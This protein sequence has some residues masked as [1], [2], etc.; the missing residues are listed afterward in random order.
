MAIAM[1]GPE[2]A[3][4]IVAVT[5]VTYLF[6][7]AMEGL[8]RS[9]DDAESKLAGFNA[10]LGIAEGKAKAAASAI[11]LL[12][13]AARAL[14]TMRPGDRGKLLSTLGDLEGE[15]GQ[16]TKLLSPEMLEG[17][18]Q[19]SIAKDATTE[20]IRAAMKPAQAALLQQ[21]YRQQQV[22][23]EVKGKELDSTNEEI[24]RLEG[25]STLFRNEDKLKEF[26]NKKQAILEKRVVIAN[27]M[28]EGDAVEKVSGFDTQRLTI[29]E[30]QK[31][32]LG[33]IAQIYENLSG[34]SPMEK[35]NTQALAFQAAVSYHDE[36]GKFLKEEQKAAQA[37]YDADDAEPKRLEKLAELHAEQAAALSVQLRG[38]PS[39]TA[40]ERLQAMTTM[41][42]KERDQA[43]LL[44]SGK[45]NTGIMDDSLI[46]ENTKD[47]DKAREGVAATTSPEAIKVARRQTDYGD[48]QRA[49]RRQIGGFGVGET[50]GNKL[51]DTQQRVLREI[52]SLQERV[53]QK[54]RDANDVARDRVRL[55]E[56]LQAQL[57]G[58][59][60]IEDRIV[61]NRKEQLQ[62]TK[63]QQHT[64]SEGILKS[65]QGELLKRFAADR[66]HALGLDRTAGGYMAAG[67]LRQYLDEAPGQGPQARRLRQEE[68]DMQPGNR[69]GYR[70]RD[71]NQLRDE[72]ISNQTA[73]GETERQAMVVMARFATAGLESVGNAAGKV[74]GKLEVVS[75]RLDG[76]IKR[77]DGMGGG[78]GG[79]KDV[80]ATTPQGGGRAGGE[81]GK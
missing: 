20:S 62:L 57:A 33:Q 55:A 70:P 58:Q 28:A 63:D 40:S 3:A 46:K 45:S 34:P 13:T 69:N 6:N 78:G 10:D 12:D 29:L 44:R 18:R 24:G 49:T 26:Q 16:G 17:I 74:A 9:S 72:I 35:L 4:G 68:R 27:S 1:M 53:N 60:S 19:A 52:A 25:K 7:K 77:L 79:K 39:I 65:S 75:V 21:V 61:Q 47:G 42:G 14:P 51:L 23:F 32:V 73:F 38:A 31:V 54:G 2:I 80:T 67:G 66:Y 30:K 48:V 5:A 81:H 71:K 56:L 76:V 11:K 15:G 36:R 41:A 37:K 8:G 43:A 64:Q 22:A 50:E 59:E